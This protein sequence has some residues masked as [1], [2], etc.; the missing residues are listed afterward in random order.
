MSD[1][2]YNSVYVDVAYSPIVNANLRTAT[3]LVPG[4]TYNTEY[5]Q[6]NVSAGVVKFYSFSRTVNGSEKPAQDFTSTEPT[7]ALTSVYLTNAF[8]SSKKLYQV[9]ANSVS[10]EYA[11]QVFS[12]ETENIREGRERC[13][14]AALVAGGTASTNTTELTSTTIK[15]QIVADKTVLQKANAKPN[16]IVL[17]PGAYSSLL[18]SQVSAAGPFTPVMNDELIKA[19]I[20]QTFLGMY[21]AISS[22]LS[23]STNTAVE[24][25]E[26]NANS[27]TLVDLSL[28]DYIIYDSKTFA[29]LD[30]L[31]Y[32]AIKDSEMFAGSKA[33]I[34]MNSGMKALRQEAVVYHKRA[35]E[36]SV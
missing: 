4:L 10:I 8:R 2:Q 34:E 6:G 32:A 14:L 31:T 22:H 15:A 12:N 23:N 29:L 20:T 28:V 16:V 33:N 26:A 35:A 27:P 24:Y 30:N 5:E 17:S 21:V 25:R 9:T 36:E 19:G 7:N 1:F 13:A 18:L 3:F 11:D